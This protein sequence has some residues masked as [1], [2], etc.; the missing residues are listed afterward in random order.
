V[1]SG[2]KRDLA[3]MARL[4]NVVAKVSGLITEADGRAWDAALVTPYI[5]HAAG[6]F[7]WD[8]LMFASD[9]PVVELAGG[10]ARWL[11]S[12]RTLT[13]GIGDVA[14]A[15][16]FAGTADATYRPASRPG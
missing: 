8:R 5:A 14:C 16:F 4:P 9:W 12:L 13:D 3:D 1:P 15:R 11:D 10:Y 7:G 2:W 6:V